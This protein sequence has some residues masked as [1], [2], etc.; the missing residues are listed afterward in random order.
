[1]APWLRPS[2]PPA[3]RVGR[4]SSSGTMRVGP[5]PTLSA[6]HAP[7]HGRQSTTLWAILLQMTPDGGHHLIPRY[8]PFV[9]RAPSLHLNGRT[10][11]IGPIRRV[12]GARPRSS[13]GGLER[14]PPK[15]WGPGVR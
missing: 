6:C 1:M 10:P 14:A 9:Q 8:I 2:V 13:G 15:P 4:G 12:E 3:G 5:L 7:R 11:A